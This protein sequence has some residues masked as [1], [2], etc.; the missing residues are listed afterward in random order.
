[1]TEEYENPFRL[2]PDGGVPRREER[3]S[4]RGRARRARRYPSGRRPSQRQRA[5]R[6]SADC[7]IIPSS[8]SG[9]R[10]QSAEG[11]VE[12]ATAAVSTGASKN[13]V[14]SS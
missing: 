13:A 5:I 6:R 1:M 8:G 7:D 9:G 2:P 14:S 11:L 4:R 3:L 10:R 12:C